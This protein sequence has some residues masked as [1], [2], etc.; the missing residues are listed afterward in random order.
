MRAQ[1]VGAILY[2]VCV[3]A[4]VLLCLG[5]PQAARGQDAN[6]EDAAVVKHLNAAITWYRQLVAA[7]ESAGQPSDALYLDN[8]RSL[9][10]QA[11]QLAFQSAE[12]EAALLL[13]ERSQFAAGANA[14]LSA[15]ASTQKQN[16]AKSAATISA[17][18]SQT[19]AQIDQLNSE[20]PKATGKK[21]EDLLAR[22]GALQDQ[23]EFNKTLQEAV[24]K[25][26]AF[27]S[28]TGRKAGGLQKEIDDLK[29]L[30]PDLFAKAQTDEAAPA[31]SSAPRDP[32][33][34]S[35]LIDQASNVFSRWGDLH[36]IEQSIADAGKV[37]D[38]A[39]QVQAPLRTRLRATVA[40][41]RGMASHPAA[42]D[43]AA[44]E[45]GRQRAIFLTARFKQLSAAAMPLAQEVVLLEECQS[46][47]RRWQDSTHR[48]CVQLLRSFLTHLSIILF[49]ILLVVVLSEVWRRATFQYVHEARMR[50]QLLLLRQIVTA[51]L[52]C[53]VLAL[54]FVSEFS[55]LATFAGFVAAGIAVALQTLLLSVAGYFFLI[56][57]HGVM[58]GDRVSVSGVT[59]DVI[60]VGLARFFLTEMA[61]TGSDLHP[62]GRVAVISNS[63]LFLGIPLLK[64]IPGTSYAWHEVVLKLER[65]SDY[66][67]AESKLLEAVKAVYS[68]YR[69]S[70]EEQHQ[71]I[72]GMMT[73]NSVIPTPQARLQ[74]VEKDLELIIRYP[75]VL[76]R[77]TE[78]DNLM[79][80]EVVETIHRTPELK[81]AVGSPTIRPSGK[82]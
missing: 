76:R 54:G 14:D 50:H 26:S 5:A 36:A 39:R 77:E 42:Q 38:E 57:R 19:Q 80:K 49:G 53:I 35:G 73:V 20:I 23:L 34:G 58:V 3:A 66:T 43:A 45:A 60:Y 46:N 51:L 40:E 69:D 72:K 37:S 1:R 7:N 78:I 25:L 55:S 11:V 81:D 18:I 56:G 6:A 70:I 59:G 63:V 24:Q 79:A 61:G 17:Q 13:E 12:T 2:G 82:A 48:E 52:L 67:L 68:Q 41:G 32:S 22:R 74:L 62:T 29:K 30:V 10:R 15:E 28:G 44:I 75:V 9:A 27:M 65:G 71:S 31:P 47:L 21:Q 64:Q 4:T 16:Y 8:A 33:G